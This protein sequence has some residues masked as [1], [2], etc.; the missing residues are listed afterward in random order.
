MIVTGQVNV[1]VGLGKLRA[2]DIN[3]SDLS[4]L[5]STLM[6]SVVDFL[7]EIIF[8]ILTLG[9]TVDVDNAVEDEVFDGVLDALIC[10]KLRGGFGEYIFKVHWRLLLV[11]QYNVFICYQSKNHASF[12]LC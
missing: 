2:E 10:P 7:R 11:V 8:V 9:N 3:A 12:W 6:A 5:N 4:Y 1:I